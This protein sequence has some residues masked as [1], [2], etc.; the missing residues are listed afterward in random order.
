M[1]KL[2]EKE[3][4]AF[5][6]DAEFC[7]TE[8]GNVPTGALVDNPSLKEGKNPRIRVTSQNNGINGFTETSDDKNYRAYSNFVSMSFLGNAFYHPYTASLD[9]KV[10][11]LQYTDTELNPDLGLFTVTMAARIASGTNYGNQLSSKD[12]ATKQIMLPVDDKG[13]PDY[14]YM[15]QYSSKLRSTLLKRYENYISEQISNLEYREVPQLEDKKWRALA[16]FGKHGF[17][18]IATTSSSIDSDHVIEGENKKVPYVT[19]KGSGNGIAHF[20]SSDNLSYGSDSAGCITVGLD[21][22]TAYWQPY[23]FITG[24][25]IQ[26]ITGKNL[27]FYLAQFVIPL[28]RKQM[29][30]KFN[31]GG[32][33][34]TLRRMKELK[35]MLPVDDAGNPD[36]NYMEQYSKNMLLR[37]YHQY[38]EYLTYPQ[39]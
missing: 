7:I 37:K 11:C 21:T 13:K 30:A 19:R 32:N 27:S 16:A 3:W 15:A 5:P 28:L 38:L 6:I 24:Q 10:H 23:V 2:N 29:M 1:K 33:G 4:K 14:D 9:M 26:V 17:L 22:Q 25:N 35:I 18:K 20:V 12:L 39:S 36:Y 31:W 34:A 8:R